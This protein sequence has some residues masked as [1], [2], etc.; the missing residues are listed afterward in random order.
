M[1]LAVLHLCSHELGVPFSV[2]FAKAA[3]KEVA[4]PS[5]KVTAKA[6][7]GGASNKE[8]VVEF[9]LHF[10]KSFYSV[11]SVHLTFFRQDWSVARETRQWQLRS[12]RDVKHANL[13]QRKWR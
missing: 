5:W 4:R 1:V 7:A 8:E 2:T 6:A 11:V 13:W 10:T 12:A 3:K 9:A